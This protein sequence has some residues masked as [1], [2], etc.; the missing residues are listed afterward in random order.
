VLRI[1]WQENRSENY[2]NFCPQSACAALRRCTRTKSPLLFFYYFSYFSEISHGVL[3]EV[4][5]IALR[6][7][8]S[9]NYSNSARTD[10]GPRSPSAHAWP[11]ARPPI[12][13]SGNF[14]AH[15]SSELPFNTSPNTSEVISYVFEPMDNFSKYPFFPPKN[16][17]VP[18]VGG[19]PNFVVGWNPN[20]FVS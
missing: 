4:L 18:E 19:S 3:K 9:E 11:F 1:A 12:D 14:P 13:T 17:I 15:M 8:W 6:E 16:H 20:I 10:G 7:K 5:R 2:L